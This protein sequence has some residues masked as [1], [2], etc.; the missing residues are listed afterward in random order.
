MS[1]VVD[2]CTVGIHRATERWPAYDS[3]QRW[4][5]FVCPLF[6]REVVE[7]IVNYINQANSKIPPID[8][9]TL[10]W[11]GDVLVKTNHLYRAEQSNYQPDR[12][13]PDEDGRYSL[14]AFDWAWFRT[15]DASAVTVTGYKLS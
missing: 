3:G 2:N 7:E 14:G 4:N 10:S 9:E 13:A 15:G 11:D 6:R 8:R 1:G 12:Y 5:G